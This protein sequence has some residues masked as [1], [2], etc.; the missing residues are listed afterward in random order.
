MLR[1]P[2]H[3]VDLSGHGS[4][5][6]AFSAAASLSRGSGAASGWNRIGVA[7]KCAPNFRPDCLGY[8]WNASGGA[9]RIPFSGWV[10]PR[11]PL[12]GCSVLWVYRNCYSELRGA[13]SW[14]AVQIGAAVFAMWLLA[15][16]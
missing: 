11:R 15:L 6:L 1:L 5:H 2:R 3:W 10:F 12:A 9:C 16:L 4:V 14:Y 7:N 13:P 8:C